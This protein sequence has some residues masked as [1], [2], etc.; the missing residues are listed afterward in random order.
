MSDPIFQ[1]YGG[2]FNS[3]LSDANPASQEKAL[4]AVEIW[5]KKIKSIDQDV[6]ELVKIILEKCYGAT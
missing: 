2:E 6:S 4:L 3:Y 1:E 5:T